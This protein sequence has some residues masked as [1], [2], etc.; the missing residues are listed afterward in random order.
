VHTRRVRAVGHGRRI[1]R[2]AV[3]AGA[4]QAER[5]SIQRTWGTT[6]FRCARL[7]RPTPEARGGAANAMLCA[8]SRHAL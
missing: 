3:S 6:G 2:R 4:T 1:D 8:Q 5:H 7:A